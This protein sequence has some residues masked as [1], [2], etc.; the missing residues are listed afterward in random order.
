MENKVPE[1]LVIKTEVIQA[2]V[3][4]L[5]TRP[6]QEVSQLIDSIHKNISEYKEE[7]QD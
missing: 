2:V 7:V 4:Y 3:S 6:F 1:K 5:A